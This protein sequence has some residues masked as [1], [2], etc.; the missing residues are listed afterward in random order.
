MTIRDAK[1]RILKLRELVDRYRYEYH[2]LNKQKISDD[3]LDALKHELLELERRFPKLVTKDSPTQRVAGKALSKFAK[4]RHEK[5]ML[6]LE[7][8]FSFEELQSWEKRIKK[9]LPS[10]RTEYFTELKTDGLA[11]SVIYENGVYAV[12]ATRG[13]GSVGE[14][15]TEN[16]KTIESLPL[17]LRRPAEPELA[18]FLKKHRDACDGKRIRTFFSDFRGRVEIRGEAYMEKKVFEEMNKRKQGSDEKEFANPRNVAAGSIRQL[19]PDIT[20]KRKLRF[21]GYDVVTD[22]GQTTHEQA[23]DLLRL[24]GIPA[25]SENRLCESLAEVQNMYESVAKKR[26]TYPYWIDGVVITLNSNVDY[27]NLGVAGKAPRA[28]CAYKFPAMQTVTTVSDI[29]VQVGRT[30]VLTPVAHLNPVSLGGTIVSRATLHNFDE[31]KRLD[32]RIGDSVILE[33]AGDIIPKVVSV[34]PDLR[35]GKETRFEIPKQCPQCGSAVEKKDGQVALTCQNPD[36]RAQQERRLAHFVSKRGFNIVGMGP[37]I[38]EKL[39]DQGLV[40]APDDL[41]TLTVDDF[42]TLPGFGAVSAKKMKDAIDASKKTTLSRFVYALGIP[43]VG[44]ET[45]VGLSSH[46]HDIESI[47]TAS[48]GDLTNVPDIGDIVARSVFDFFHDKKNRIAIDS[49]R[50]LGV[51]IQKDSRVKT[52]VGVAGKTFV[53][54]GS[55]ETFSRD[56]AKDMLRSKGGKIASAVSKN[57]DY[58]VVGKEPGSKYDDARALGIRCI[59]EKELLLMIGE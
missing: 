29:A 4:V 47:M 37:Q 22:I 26:E 17:R 28:S 34:L 55:M 36:C 35:T 59:S 38:I 31:M 5:R 25:G 15:V 48:V 10:L 32:V 45:A 16:V 53:I 13:D 58:V 39:M 57:V 18:A 9:L 19:D 46:F 14:N 23:H 40:A 30:G 2:V 11:I 21:H 50:E 42:V 33:K 27:E 1:E 8:I 56:E 49:M 52:F 20:A 54:T 41:F 51:E 44:E 43:H 7:D 12:A 6:S 3:A 24:L